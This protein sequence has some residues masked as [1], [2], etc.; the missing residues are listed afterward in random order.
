MG[1]EF[2]D[3]QSKTSLDSLVFPQEYEIKHVIVSERETIQSIDN[4]NQLQGKIDSLCETSC[5]PLAG[6]PKSMI[7][8]RGEINCHVKE[9]DIPLTCTPKVR[10]SSLR[11]A[12][13][14]LWGEEFIDVHKTSRKVAFTLAEVLITLGI[15][16]VVAAITM[17]ILLNNVESQV[18]AK[19]IENIRQKLS[20]VT[21]KMAVQSGLIGYD[22][23]SAFIQ[24]MQKHMKIAKVCD[25]NHLDACWPTKEVVL[26]DEGKTW[27]ISKT[28]NAKTLK[29]NKDIADNWSDT[30]GIVTADGTSMILSYD[31]TC[32]FDVDKDGLKSDGTISN[33]ANCLSGVYDWN[34]GKKPNK[35]GKDIR[36]LGMATGLGNECGGL[37]LGDRCFTAP[38][39]PKPLTRAE[40]EAQKGTLGIKYCNYDQDYWAGA[41]AQCKG[42]KNMPT[43][44]DLA[45]LATLLYKGNPT[46]G[47]EES[48]YDLTLDTSV[49]K[50]MGFGSS[51]F[52]VW[53][54]EEFYSLVAYYRGFGSSHT[55]WGNDDRDNSYSQAVCLGD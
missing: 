24:E 45:K 1:G 18:Q 6:G 42:V 31:K 16:G 44:E 38:F 52:I 48:K 50:A 8:R 29:I 3:G 43:A 47:A 17:P 4:Q 34:G 21:D 14:P 51:D 46:V 12:S 41:V 9:K 22:D 20:K 25:N 5:P 33:S 2:V 37:E 10:F 11:T 36:T 23:T 40:C 28:K 49:A 13:S 19:R 54:G 30:I 55:G 32:D 15:I 26:N 39:V 7:S 35:L 27:E 53:S